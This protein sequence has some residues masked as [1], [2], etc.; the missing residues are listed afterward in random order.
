MTQ[1]RADGTISK[2]ISDQ[3][4]QGFLLGI[5]Q[6][7]T[8]FLPVSSSGHLIL[9][10]W[11]L[12]WQPLG[13]V[14]DIMVH[15]GTLLAVLVYFRQEWKQFLVTAFQRMSGRSRNRNTILM[16]AIILGTIPAVVAGGLLRQVIEE[17]LRTPIVTASCLGLFGLLLW[18]AD[19]RGAKDRSLRSLTRKDGILIGIAQALALMPGVSR[20]GITL[21][22]GLALGLNRSDAARFAFLLSA[23]VMA[24][25]G[26]SAVYDLLS[27]RTAEAVAGVA[28]SALLLGVSSSF[29]SGI[30]CIRFFL[31]FLE[32]RTLLPFVVYRSLL[33][34]VIFSSSL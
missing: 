23:P 5:L 21:T 31:R 7:L 27:A 11:I 13:L 8:E 6:G 20:A 10:P 30:L 32:R 16:E 24:L 33:A 3:T 18:W 12:G 19:R 34:V 25:A 17:Y 26:A 2:M 28:D 1:A 14:F 9:V 29:V 15:I 4:L 22:A